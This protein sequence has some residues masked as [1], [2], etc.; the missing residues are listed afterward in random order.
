MS[1]DATPRR[2][3]AQKRLGRP[4]GCEILVF[5]TTMDERDAEKARAQSLGV[6]GVLLALLVLLAL[7]VVAGLALLDYLNALFTNGG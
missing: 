4:F 3:A 5:S 2:R 6:F 7:A 1:A